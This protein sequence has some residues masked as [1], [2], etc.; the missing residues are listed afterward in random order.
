M[1]A[2]GIAVNRVKDTEGSRRQ[3][4]GGRHA[5]EHYGAVVGH[6][7][8]EAEHSRIACIDKESMVPDIDHVL[9]GQRFHLGK[10]HDHAVGSIAIL[11]NDVPGKSN[12]DRI[13]MPVQVPAL[14]LVIGDAVTGIELEA[15][16]DEHGENR[17][18]I[19]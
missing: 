9:L 3:I 14:A 18:E 4:L 1:V 17:V 12:F 15:A 8:Q 6:R 2:I 11:A 13:A 5:I 7:L 10:I 19:R 16:G